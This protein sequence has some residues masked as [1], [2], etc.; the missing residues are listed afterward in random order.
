MCPVVR[1]PLPQIESMPGCPND[2]EL[3][4]PFARFALLWTHARA[5]RARQQEEKIRQIKEAYNKTYNTR[6]PF[7]EKAIFGRTRP[8]EHRAR[9]DTQ[10]RVQSA[11]QQRQLEVS[12]PRNP[13]GLDVTL[14]QKRKPRKVWLRRWYGSEWVVGRAVRAMSLPTPRRLH[15]RHITQDTEL[16]CSSLTSHPRGCIGHC[17]LPLANVCLPV[18]AGVWYGFAVCSLISTPPVGRQAG[19]C[20]DWSWQERQ[21]RWWWWWWW[22]SWRQW[23]W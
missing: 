23:C 19:W 13:F 2:N 5:G 7:E 20:G 22:R 15:S 4:L 16:T 3:L 10:R 21:C 8:V 18:F 17:L 6:L 9:L 12:S 1:S 14:R 11:P